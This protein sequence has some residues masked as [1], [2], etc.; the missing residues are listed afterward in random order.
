MRFADLNIIFE[1]INAKGGKGEQ[2]NHRKALCREEWLSLLVQIVLVRHVAS[3]D[4]LGVAA[5]F[6]H[7][8]DGISPLLPPAVHHDANTFRSEQCYIESVDR[9]LRARET[10]LRTSARLEPEAAADWLAAR[11]ADVLSADG[12][13]AAA[14]EARSRRG[15]TL[16]RCP[17]EPCCAQVWSTRS[18]RTARAPS[19][20]PSTRPR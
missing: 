17:G 3:D 16:V 7:F 13:F 10:E 6:D 9:S 19:A 4:A 5:A 20:T 15:L 1:G 2:F 18:S 12:R 11:T 14:A 8:V